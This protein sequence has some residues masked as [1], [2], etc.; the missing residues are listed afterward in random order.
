M[1]SETEKT[2]E[3]QEKLRSARQRLAAKK[4][5][6]TI[7][8]KRAPDQQ[9]LTQILLVRNGSRETDEDGL[10]RE[11]E[12]E[13]VSIGTANRRNIV[14][15]FDKTPPK[16]AC[17]RFWELRWAFGCPL[18][19]NYC[20]L[21][22][23][24][25]GKMEPRYVPVEHVLLAL[26]Q[27][28]Q[29][30]HFNA[31]KPAIL[32]S[33]EL[34]DSLMNPEKMARIADAFDDPANQVGHKLLILSKFG[35]SNTKFLVERRRRNMICAWSLNALEV[36]KIWERRAP[37]P[38]KRLEAARMV[39]EVGYDTRIRID[40]IFPIQ[41][42]K[43]HYAD[44]MYRIFAEGDFEPTRIILGTPRGLWKTL[45]FAKRTG[46]DMAWAQY[47]EKEETGWGKKIHFDARK[48]I[49]EF[50]Y[51]TLSDIG[52]DKL[53]VTI[54]KETIS[55]WKELGLR[56]LE[57]PVTKLPLCNCYTYLPQD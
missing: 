17:G 47:F 52:Y 35:P 34:A 4:A 23:T 41:E 53:K 10:V 49:Y 14:K 31:G 12:P 7:R 26:K 6:H 13:T 28:F 51:D 19:C 55:M 22:G 33:G 20:Y 30:K 38:D 1:S 56:Y 29:D 36:A 54:C 27:L 2:T 45:V 24:M 16:I 39:A 42:W 5:W 9:T 37:P 3:D 43:E 57:D 11:K 18:D 8:M 48:Q 15:Q 44:L 50:F 21:R 25:R 46:M 32:N 40:P